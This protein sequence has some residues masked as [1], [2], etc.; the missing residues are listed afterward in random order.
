MSPPRP[1]VTMAI[2]LPL[3]PVLLFVFLA[4]HVPAAH[5]DPALLPTTY[6]ASMCPESSMC[7]N[8]SIRYPF[9]LS[10][11]TRI[12]T[13]YNYNTTSYSCGYTD[14]EISCQGEGPKATPARAVV[15]PVV[16]SGKCKSTSVFWTVVNDLRPCLDA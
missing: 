15:L 13:D 6:D 9:Y 8:I 16:I 14:L 10:S 11:T 4:V 7:G 12:I 1:L 2:H 5:G 3:L